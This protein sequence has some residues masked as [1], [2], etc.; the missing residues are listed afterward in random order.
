MRFII[1][2][3]LIRNSFAAT[4]LE[5]FIVRILFLRLTNFASFSSGKSFF[6]SCR[7]KSKTLTISSCREKSSW[8]ENLSFRASESFLNILNSGNHFS[9]L[10]VVCLRF[11]GQEF[12]YFFKM[13]G[14]QKRLGQILE[15]AHQGFLMRGIKLGKYVIQK[16]NR[17]LAG[18]LPHIF[19][20]QKLQRQ[21]NAP[22]FSPRNKSDRVL[23]VY[24]CR[25]LVSVGTEQRQPAVFFFGFARLEFFE[26]R[27]LCFGARHEVGKI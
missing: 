22:H 27:G 2:P 7:Y 20:F 9:R 24:F 15:Q 8:R 12:V 4:E 21:G 11:F 14:G 3:S 17:R 1:P 19:L 18:F 10:Y 23:P 26:Q 5:V 16:Q 6:S 25:E 13:S